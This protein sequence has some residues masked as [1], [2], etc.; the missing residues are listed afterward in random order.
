MTLAYTCNDFRNEFRIGYGVREFV[1]GSRRPRLQGID[2]EQI[3][4][5][6]NVDNHA[7][8][9]IGDVFVVA[10]LDDIHEDSE[11]GRGSAVNAR[12]LARLKPFTETRAG[13][14]RT[15]SENTVTQEAL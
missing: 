14:T 6:V 10:N 12:R 9:G 13:I 15:H 5:A 8:Y 1:I 7:I 11:V 3:A 2:A 4:S